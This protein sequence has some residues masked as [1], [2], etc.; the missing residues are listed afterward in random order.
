MDNGEI[1]IVNLAKGRLGADVA[2]ITGGLITSSLMNAAFTRHSLPEQARRPY[3]LYVDEFHNLTTRAFAGLLSEARKYGLGLTLAHQHLS[4]AENSVSEAI[5]GNVGSQVIFRVGAN[6]APGFERQL[7]P[8]SALDLQNQPN[9][10]AVAVVTH[11]GVRSKPFS[12]S[13]YPP[14]R[15]Q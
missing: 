5:L 15:L 12:A 10:R 14:Y 6:D 11:D 8:F 2:N 3:L 1:L 9:H 13:M 4:Q 7:P